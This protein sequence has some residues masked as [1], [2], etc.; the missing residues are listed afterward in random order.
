MGLTN[1]DVDAAAHRAAKASSQVE[2]IG[3]HRD[4]RHHRLGITDQGGTFDRLTKFTVFDQIPF[5]DGE[6]ELTRG[7]NT[8]APITLQ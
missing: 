1:G 3:T 6:V 2:V 4:P 8:A 5:F 7:A